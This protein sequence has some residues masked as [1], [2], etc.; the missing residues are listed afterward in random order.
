MERNIPYLREIHCSG[1]WSPLLEKLNGWEKKDECKYS[2]GDGVF[3]YDPTGD[4]QNPIFYLDLNTDKLVSGG[5][6][7]ESPSGIEVMVRGN[8]R[9]GSKKTGDYTLN[10]A[11]VTVSNINVEGIWWRELLGTECVLET[12][13]EYDPLIDGPLNTKHFYKPPN[14]Y[15]TL[16]EENPSGIVHHIGWEANNIAS[17][18]QVKEILKIIKWPVIWEG[19]ID[20]SYVIHF[21]GPD[22]RIH[23]FFSTSDVL[24]R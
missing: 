8:F 10:H 6:M 24:K 3:V 15:I 5:E 22:E 13:Q 11:A 7:V 4:S 21:K 14:F 23:D 16:R 17:L 19:S 1:D 9:D 2:N 20:K 18:H 12:D